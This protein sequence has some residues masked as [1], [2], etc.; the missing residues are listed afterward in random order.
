M[1]H[2][3]FLKDLNFLVDVANIANLVIESG[4]LRQHLSIP[5]VL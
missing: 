4:V 5:V 3:D 1:F 2:S